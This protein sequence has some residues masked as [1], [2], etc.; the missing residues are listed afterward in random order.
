VS[1]IISYLLYVV[2]FFRILTDSLTIHGRPLGGE[3]NLSGD[4]DSNS[5]INIL[6]ISSSEA[7]Y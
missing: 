1:K 6:S 7:V 5:F 3:G 4:G 2:L